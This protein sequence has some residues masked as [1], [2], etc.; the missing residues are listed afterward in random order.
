MIIKGC[1]GTWRYLDCREQR[2][3]QV[4]EDANI[5][6]LYQR[7]AKFKRQLSK[8]SGVQEHPEDI[9]SCLGD[10][11]GTEVMCNY[12]CAKWAMGTKILCTATVISDYPSEVA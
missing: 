6:A 3:K 9:F 10:A 7:Y 1:E 12:C 4:V 11:V 2:H 8:G 5:A